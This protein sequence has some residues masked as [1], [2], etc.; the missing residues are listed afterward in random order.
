MRRLWLLCLSLLP[1]GKEL[2]AQDTLALRHAVKAL[3]EALV[4]RNDKQIRN[5]VRKSV[6]YVH[7]NGWTESRAE[8][9]QNL[10]NGTL[11]YKAIYPEECRVSAEGKMGVVR[12]KGRYEV[13][14]GQKTATY[15]LK[16]LQIW[17]YKRGSWKL[18]GRTSEQLP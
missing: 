16:V 2:F 6:R 14:M 4:Q 17:K 18:V 11:L 10:H 9:I 12:S 1:V 5:L 13:I 3:D 7:S 15:H 8:M